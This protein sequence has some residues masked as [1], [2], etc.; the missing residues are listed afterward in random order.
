MW[1]LSKIDL[2]SQEYVRRDPLQFINVHWNV[3]FTR[4]NPM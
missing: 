4:P 1:Y 2:G 3:L